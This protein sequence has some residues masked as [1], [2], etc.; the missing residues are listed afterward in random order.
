MCVP[1]R[2]TEHRRPPQSENHPYKMTTT[3]RIGQ[4]QSDSV[5]PTF[6]GWQ[7]Q[8]T[9]TQLAG[10]LVGLNESSG[11]EKLMERWPARGQSQVGCVTCG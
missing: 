11:R 6:A 10:S 4:A 3:T 2:S 9:G 7:R 5:F 1:P 8:T